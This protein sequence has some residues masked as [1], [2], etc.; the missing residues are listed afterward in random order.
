MK[1]II[2]GI[3]FEGTVQEMLE[4]LNSPLV[5]RLQRPVDRSKLLANT[6]KPLPKLTS[7]GTVNKKGRPKGCLDKVK[8]KPKSQYLNPKKVVPINRLT[9]AIE[10][11]GTTTAREEVRR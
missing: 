4:L 8:R 2:N 7:V 1:A 3:E 9:N 11:W 10:S 6:I 5:N